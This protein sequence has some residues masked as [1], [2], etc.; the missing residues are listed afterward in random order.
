LAVC[1]STSLV[2]AGWQTNRRTLSELDVDLLLTAAILHDVGKLDELC[3]SALS[4]TP[5]KA[6]FSATS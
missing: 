1:S 3:S 6:S 2:C 4:A 5:S